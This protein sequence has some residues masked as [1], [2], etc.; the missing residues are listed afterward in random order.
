M[1]VRVYSL[2]LLLQHKERENVKDREPAQK[3]SWVVTQFLGQLFWL[4]IPAPRFQ[5]PSVLFLF[6]LL[7]INKNTV[8]N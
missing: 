2:D 4:S 3:S 8:L 6:L 7:L 5:F 1:T